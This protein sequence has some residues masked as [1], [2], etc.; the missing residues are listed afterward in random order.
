MGLEVASGFQSPDRRA[1]TL[2]METQLCISVSG[3]PV[4]GTIFRSLPQD[5]YCSPSF[6]AM[7][8]ALLP[9]PLQAVLIPESTEW[10]S[11]TSP[12]GCYNTIGLNCFVKKVATSLR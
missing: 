10:L 8:A 1:T 12:G 11:F 3:S 2:G 6:M 7:V 5:P 9:Q 4:H